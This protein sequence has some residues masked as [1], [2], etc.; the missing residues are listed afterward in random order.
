MKRRVIVTA[1]VV[2]LSLGGAS[3]RAQQPAPSLGDS[4]AALVENIF[5]PTG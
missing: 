2:V 4:P 5:V 3:A 1:A